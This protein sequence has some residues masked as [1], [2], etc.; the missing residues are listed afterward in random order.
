MKAVIAAV[1]FLSETESD[2]R[3]RRN[4]V[5]RQPRLEV[6][7]AEVKAAGEIKNSAEAQGHLLQN[8]K[9]QGQRAAGQ[10]ENAAVPAINTN[11]SCPEGV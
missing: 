2:S 6:D 8:E 11:V 7:Q 4:N 10:K 9:R 3:S 5:G 1:G